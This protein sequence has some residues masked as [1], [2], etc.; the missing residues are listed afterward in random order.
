MF[1]L[2]D[3]PILSSKATKLLAL[4]QYT[5][6]VDRRLTKP[7]IKFLFQEIFGVRVISVNTIIPSKKKKLRLRS[8]SFLSLKKRAVVTI[9]KN[10]FIS[11]YPS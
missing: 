4:S 1:D 5:F 10:D 11:F 2:I 8:E 6:L 7:D 9:D 3:S